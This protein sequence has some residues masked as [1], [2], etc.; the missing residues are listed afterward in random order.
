MSE[1]FDLF[2]SDAYRFGHCSVFPYNRQDTL[3]FSDD[4][5]LQLYRASKP[6]LSSTFCGMADTSAPAIC[7]YLST[8][9]PLLLMC[10]DDDST[11]GFTVVGYAFP[12]IIAGPRQGSLSPDPGRSM[13]I[14]YAIM[15]AYYRAPEAVVCMMLMGVYFFN[16][17]NLH[18]LQG[19]SLPSNHLT[20]KFLS[21]FGTRDVGI[22][23][24]FLFDGQSMV[25]SHQ[26][27]LSRLDFE[28]YCTK[29]LLNCAQI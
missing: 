18:T 28:S 4:F 14:G 20:R 1:I 8:R 7:A 25:D 23:P 29:V 5:L 15:P 6:T 10:V 9:S 16:E 21:Q 3:T 12:T 22:L 17:F 19:Q 26:S 24:K 2:A 27:S 13:L 11:Q